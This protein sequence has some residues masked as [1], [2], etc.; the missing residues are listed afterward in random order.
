ML[1]FT[2]PTMKMLYLPYARTEAL[3]IDPGEEGAERELEARAIAGRI[4]ELMQ[5]QQVL[6][7]GTGKLRPLRYGDIVI[8]VRSIR[9]FADIFTEVQ[10]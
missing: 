10:I 5:S 7:K 3:V 4:R 8:L 2:S 1:C 6:D 9:G